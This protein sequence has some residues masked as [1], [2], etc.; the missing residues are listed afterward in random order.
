MYK[1][2]SW[3]NRLLSKGLLFLVIFFAAIPTV[4]AS[5]NLAG[6]ITYTYLGNNRV[7]IILTTYTDPSAA[8]VDRCEVD[9]EIWSYS[10]SSPQNQT[11]VADLTNVPRSNGPF[12]N[13]PVYPNLNCPNA[14]M[15]EYLFGTVKKNIYEV[16]YTF[17]GP[18]FYLIRFYDHARLDNIKN[19]VQSGTQTFFLETTVF[20]NNFLGPE[21]SPQFLN[22]PLDFACVDRVWT[23]SPGAWDPDQGDSLYYELVECRQYDPPSIPNPITTTGYTF[24]DD[25]LHGNS[26]M[27]MDPRTGLITWD[28]PRQIGIY[29]IAYRVEEYRNGVFVGLAYRDM[30]IWVK[31]CDNDPPEIETI[32]DTCV[33]AGDTLQ[34][35]VV[36]WDPNFY[37]DSLY[38]YLNNGGNV[39]NGPFAVPINPATIEFV[40]QPNPPTFPIDTVDTVRAVVTWITDCSHIRSQFYQI[41]FYAHDNFSYADVFGSG[42]GGFD[43][44]LSRHKSVTINV[45]PRPVTGLTAQAQGGQVLLNWDPHNCSNATGYEIYRKIGSSGWAQDT[46]CCDQ[47]P[48]Q[49]GYQLLGTTTGHLSTTFTDASISDAQIGEQICYVV[50]AT[51]DDG[52]RSCAS[53][54]ACLQIDKFRPALTNASVTV[55]STTAGEM[56][57]A[58]AQPDRDTTGFF[59]EPFTYTLY[60]ADDISGPANYIQLASNIPFDDTTYTDTGL[61]TSDMGYRYKVE[62]YDNNGTF[63]AEGNEGSSVYLSVNAG[64]KEIRLTWSEFVPWSNSEYTIY[65]LDPG[66][67]TYT[68]IAVVQGNGGSLHTYTD[69]GLNNFEEYCYYVQSYGG[70][71]APDIKFPLEND[72]EEKCATPTDLT[73]PCIDATLYDT[74]SECQSYHLQILW[75]DGDSLCAGDL[76]YHTIYLAEGENQ[77]FR[78]IARVDTPANG[79][80][81]TPGAFGMDPPSIAFCFGITATDSLGNES[82]MLTWCFDNCP[83][84]EIEN[85]F[86]P[87]NDG[88]ND[89]FGIYRD[90]SMKVSQA[91]IYDRW[92]SEVWSS[93]NVTDPHEIWDGRDNKGRNAPDGV[94]YYYIRFDQDRLVGDFP[95]PPIVGHVTLLR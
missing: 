33:Y 48:L 26:T 38:F 9:L 43:Q 21:N 7:K 50:V 77:P 12:Q 11:K 72:S 42:P 80:D 54:E 36:S 23:H 51:F 57:V 63:V 71:T 40:N 94:Y 44:L 55:T 74:L 85:V 29:N 89:W 64:D 24:P 14:H 73:P 70:Y 84:Y 2:G 79:F 92:G 28:A 67:P 8:G 34:F 87:N 35:D 46:I 31:T 60:R 66:A 49:A 76:A 53:N 1:K 83:T 32:T 37:D 86:T 39:N 58:W 45:V 62:V 10:A 13:D 88:F 6:E 90:R 93:T 5:H 22:R 15:G 78:Q 61:N 3:T 52:I 47:S 69:T 17:G 18:G 56:F 25:P 91:V 27:N 81:F 82:E 16:E 20:I 95:R 75:Q 30:A 65:R 41:D 59:V 68:Q 4:Q 19:M